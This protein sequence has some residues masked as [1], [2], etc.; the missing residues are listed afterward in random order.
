MGGGGLFCNDGNWLYVKYFKRI[1]YLKQ[2]Y[3]LELFELM[4][5]WYK[6]KLMQQ[7]YKFYV[8]YIY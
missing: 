4:E 1:Y 8:E 6:K 2:K 5:K 3:I 7:E